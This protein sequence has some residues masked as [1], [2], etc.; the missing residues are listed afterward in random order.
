M[1]FDLKSI[2]Q[3]LTITS[4]SL[5]F[6]FYWIDRSPEYASIAILTLFGYLYWTKSSRD[7]FALAFT[8]TIT[9]FV[10][11]FFRFVPYLKWPIDFFLLA[12]VGF[13]SLKF[14]FKKEVKL[15]WKFNLGRENP[16]RVFEYEGKDGPLHAKAF[17]LRKNSDAQIRGD[18]SNESGV[19]G[20]GTYNVSPNSWDQHIETMVFSNRENLVRDLHQTYLKDLEQSR[21]IKGRKT[22]HQL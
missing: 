18:A 14:L 7:E 13:L 1:N 3:I 10:L 12:A 6:Y 22:F 16:A 2:N 4:Y 8:V 17:L 9:H 11:W 20:V 19:A 21:E 15:N 5:F